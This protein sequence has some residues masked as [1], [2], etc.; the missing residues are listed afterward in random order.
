MQNTLCV[1]QILT[2]IRPC[3]PKKD[4]TTATGLYLPEIQE[5]MDFD[6]SRLKSTV[7][8]LG[9]NAKITIN[10]LGR[11]KGAVEIPREVIDEDILNQFDKRK[12]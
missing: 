11:K 8:K 10:F 12:Y 7:V 1:L 6:Q 9:G 5:L 4:G 2:F 3:I